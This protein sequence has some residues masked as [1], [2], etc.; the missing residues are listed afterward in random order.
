VSEPATVAVH[1]QNLDM[2]CEPVEQRAGQPRHAGRHAFSMTPNTDVHSSNGKLLVTIAR[3]AFVAL[4]EDLEQQFGAG[5]ARYREL[6]AR[7]LSIASTMGADL[8]E[9]DIRKTITI[10]RPER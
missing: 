6:D 3:A 9:A 4:A 8:G 5:D 10:V 1:L 7:L 2:M